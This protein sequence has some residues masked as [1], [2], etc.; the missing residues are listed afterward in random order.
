MNQI[1]MKRAIDLAD[2]GMQGGHGG[3]FGAVVVKEN[4]IVGEGFNCVLSAH[5]PT[6]HGE[7]VAIRDACAKLHT[8]DLSGCEIH[9]TGEPCPMCLAAIYWARIDRIHYGFTIE[10]A[11][12]VGF[13]DLNFHKELQKP[14]GQR[15]VVAIQCC[16]T[17][18]LELLERYRSLPDVRLY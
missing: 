18:A 15:K 13:D 8:H 4:V 6:A 16:H 2:Q 9:T 17:E 12:S 5:D 1:F 11:A 7:V 3:P 10:D 14:A